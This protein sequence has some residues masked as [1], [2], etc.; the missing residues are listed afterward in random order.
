MSGIYT[1]LHFLKPAAK[2]EK[3]RQAIEN[4]KPVGLMF[5]EERRG[6]G[7]HSLAIYDK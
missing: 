3:A 6:S 5:W 4:E 7:F 2:R 1:F